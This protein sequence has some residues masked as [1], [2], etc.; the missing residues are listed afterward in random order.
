M[1]HAPSRGA[2]VAV[3][4]SFSL[5]FL[6]PA[7]P[8]AASPQLVSAGGGPIVDCTGAS[9]A[10]LE[11]GMGVQREAL[12]RAERMYRQA[13]ET[14]RA[15]ADP[16]REL[17]ILQERTQKWLESQITLT[18]K[19]RALRAAGLSASRTSDLLRLTG[20]VEKAISKV[21]DAWKTAQT[22]GNAGV[23]GLEF[24]KAISENADLLESYS[25]F[26][27]D[28]GLGEEAVSLLANAGFGPAGGLV[29]E[30][31][32]LARDYALG[33]AGEV[34]AERDLLTMRDNLDD[35]RRVVSNNES[36]ISDLR[37]MMA[38]N[39]KPSRTQPQDS[40]KPSPPQDP[41]SVAQP[42]PASEPAPAKKKGGGKALS[43]LLATGTAIGGGIYIANT[44]A[45]LEEMDLDGDGGSSGSGQPSL[46]SFTQWTCSGS[47]C[48]GDV[49]INFPMKI[50]SGS[51]IVF[52]SPGSWAGQALV[53]PSAPPGDVTIRMTRSY[54]TCYG[55]QTGLAIWNATNANGPNTWSLTSSIPVTCR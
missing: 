32:N 1:S 10:R 16:E 31:L 11:S 35:L 52:S 9:L 19:V 24:G 15:A 49:V 55:T 45:S 34:L 39:C 14:H 4:A 17:K 53:S 40:P 20:Q 28:S 25:T 8:I 50:S 22:A 23:A 29:V 30:G 48:A 21:Q 6:L 13:E 12:Q 33:A 2:V 26:L 44:L 27:G 41:P 46:R 54:N 3:I 51:I 47:S 37:A 42:T 43:L 38:E 7:R 36:R 5:S 18:R